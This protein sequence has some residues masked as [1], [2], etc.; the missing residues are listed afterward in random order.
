DVI[1]TLVNPKRIL[2]LEQR[3]DVA[4][5]RLPRDKLRKLA[6]I[7]WLIAP[8]Y[9]GQNEGRASDRKQAGHF[10]SGA[11]DLQ[12]SGSPAG[13]VDDHHLGDS[14]RCGAPVTRRN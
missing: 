1:W 12:L 13:G 8:P 6:T 11:R 3:L 7:C 14:I 2:V 10:A 9:F 4:R 5:R